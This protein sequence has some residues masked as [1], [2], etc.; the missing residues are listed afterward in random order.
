ML[1]CSMLRFYVAYVEATVLAIHHRK[2]NFVEDLCGRSF[3]RA[4]LGYKFKR[5]HEMFKVRMNED[6]KLNDL[7]FS[8]MEVLFYLEKNQDHPVNQQELCTAIEVS[9]PTMIGLINR[10]EEKEMLQRRVDPENRRNRYIEMT[11]KAHE[12]MLQTKC[13]RERNDQLIT[14]GMSEAQKAELDRLLTMVYGNM[15]DEAFWK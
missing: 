14:R 2:G 15:Q 5:I 13:R 8:Q 11:Q 6:M 7:T 4:P 1:I 9:H 3:E 12:V 10:L